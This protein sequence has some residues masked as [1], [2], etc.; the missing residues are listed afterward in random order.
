MEHALNYESPPADVFGHNFGEHARDLKL[1]DYKGNNYL[2]NTTGP[3]CWLAI[4][5]VVSS[6]MVHKSTQG[7][8]RNLH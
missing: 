1:G 4:K 6:R 7:L 3:M 2:Q 8:V 5:S